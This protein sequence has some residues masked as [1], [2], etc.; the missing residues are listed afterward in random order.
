MLVVRRCLSEQPGAMPEITARGRH[1]HAAGGALACRCRQGTKGW[2][3]GAAGH[4]G[5]HQRPAGRARA[6]DAAVITADSP[7]RSG[8]AS[9]TAP[10][11]LPLASSVRLPCTAGA[12]G[13]GAAAADGQE[14]KPPLRPDASW[15]R[16]SARPGPGGNQ[17]L[18]PVP[19]CTAA[20]IPARSGQL[21]D[22]L[23]SAST[24]T[25][26]VL[27]PTGWALRPRCCP[28]PRPS[29][30]EACSPRCWR[31]TVRRP[32]N[33]SWGRI[34]R[35]RVMQ[36]ER[37]LDRPGSCS[38]QGH[39]PLR[40]PGG[41]VWPPSKLAGGSTPMFVVSTMGRHL[42]DVF[43]CRGR[44]A[45]KWKCTWRCAFAE[46]GGLL[47]R[48]E[49]R[50]SPVSACRR[51]ELCRSTPWRP[52][53][54]RGSTSMGQR[55][56]GAASAGAIQARLAYRR[57]GPLT[58]TDANLLWAGLQAG[59]LSGGVRPRRRSGPMPAAGEPAVRGAASGSPG[60]RDGR[61]SLEAPG[62]R[63][64]RSP[65]DRDGESDAGGISI[66][67][68]H[69]IRGA[70]LVLLRRRRRPSTPAPSRAAGIR[71]C[72]PHPLA[73][74]LSGLWHRPGRP[75]GLAARGGGA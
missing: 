61:A 71:R 30:V 35:L 8:S 56:G 59:G 10:I 72:C 21:G 13:G 27:S 17:Q 68:G 42:H 45:G 70:T 26:L 66:Q 54:A 55:A 51:N 31:P 38:R 12:G 15:R 34:G 74:V 22:W 58:I 63:A 40:P 1:A 9:A 69:D 3:E 53:V 46:E 19:C 65:T 14:L 43:H 20:A 41:L 48:L 37:A 62:R 28:A 50:R 4:H 57:G 11:C 5:G 6:P 75:S 7:M 52:G 47:E 64:L 29:V 60:G 36:V 25:R 44:R 67:R 2:R 32:C 39:D 23:A 33:A 73:G 49:E 16:R 24:S 18:A